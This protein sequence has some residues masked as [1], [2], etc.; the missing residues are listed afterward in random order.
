[1]TISPKRMKAIYHFSRLLLG[2]TFI[3]S[4]FVKGQD[5][6]GTTFKI[7]DYFV[8]YGWDWAM[9][10]ALVLSILLCTFEFALGAGLLLNLQFRLVSWLTTALMVFFTGLTLYDAIYNPVPDCGCFGD[11]IKL[12]NWQTFWKNVVL[13]VF[14]VLM[15]YARRK[16]KLQPNN[17]KGQFLTLLVIA[18]FFSLF[19]YWAFTHLPVFD[20]LPWKKGNRLYAEETLPV[21]YFVSYR[22]NSTGET[23]EYP[24]DNFPFN[25]S[26]WMS[27]WNFVSSRILDP[28]QAIRHELVIVDTFG[29]D[30]TETYLRNPDYQFIITLYNPHDANPAIL[31]KISALAKEIESS[32]HSVIILTTALMEEIDELRKIYQWTEDVFNA[33]DIALKMMARANPGLVLLKDGIVINKWNGRNLPTFDELTEK[34]FTRVTANE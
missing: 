33:D 29:D 11:A 6:L 16:S 12:T 18:S 21:Q 34:Y 26:V 15:F 13:L 28:N 3:F 23:R 20:F 5:P 31:E 22:H 2:L 7:E 4:G 9:P 25:D 24:A 17:L 19:S 32:G 10:Y 30:V 14:V 8:A 1:M 27:Q